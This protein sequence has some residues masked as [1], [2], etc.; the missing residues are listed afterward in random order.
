MAQCIYC[1]TVLAACSRKNGTSSLKVH[2]DACAKARAEKDGQTVLN[3]Q[4]SGNVEGGGML[5]NWKFNQAEIR[6][7]LAEMIIIDELPFIFVEHQGFRRFM[8][9]C[10]PMFIIPSRRSIREDCFRLFLDGRDKL[11]EF[12]KTTCDGRVSITTDGWTSV[13]NFNYICITTHFVGKDWKLH[14]KIINFRRIKSHKGVDVGEAI[15]GC[16]EEWGLKSIFTVTVDNASANDTAVTYLKEQLK[17][18]G[19]SVMDGNYLHMRCVAHIVNLIVGVGLEEMGLSI[20]RVREAIRWVCGSPS[21]EQYFRELADFKRIE[22]KKKLSLDVPTRWNSTFI[23]LD[24]ALIF[25]RAFEAV[26]NLDPTFSADLKTK[27]W[28]NVVLGPPTDDDWK[29]VKNLTNYLKFFHELTLVASGTKYVTSHLF[30]TEVSR[31]FHHIYKMEK[32]SDEDI[33]KMAAKMKD[34]V[35][36]YWSEKDGTN[37]RLNRLMYLAPVFDPRYRWSILQ[38]TFPKLYGEHRG[39]ELLVEVREELNAMFDVYK[40]KQ[41]RERNENSQT[42]SSMST[43]EGMSV[44]VDDGDDFYADYVVVPTR[45][46]ERAELE[47]YLT[48]EREEM[49]ENGKSFDVLGWWKLNAFKCPVLSEM[50]KDIL[51]V[52]ISTVA[53]ES[54]FSTG[55]RVLDDFRSSLTPTIVEALIC[56]EDWLRTSYAS[57]PAEEGLEDQLEFERGNCLFRLTHFI[58]YVL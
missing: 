56:A 27:K 43:S 30:L 4:P 58:S 28:K 47:K 23:M 42:Q 11:K 52:P 19:T 8:V 10:C 6:I 53:S 25:E 51:A 9:V 3:L 54:C 16:L 22:S 40:E 24:T 57:V 18:W 12:F 50:A 1:D 36:K 35:F 26:C 20:R 34:K 14:K 55:G 5:T 45:V 41:A 2:V 38:F 13:Q 17:I 39:E 44:L 29:S 21:R 32:S 48:G 49:E 33:R 15:A 46:G 31:L 7:A 37:K